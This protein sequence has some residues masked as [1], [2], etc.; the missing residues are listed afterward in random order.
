MKF[1]YFYFLDFDLGMRVTKYLN[2]FYPSLGKTWSEVRDKLPSFRKM[3]SLSVILSLNYFIYNIIYL[4]IFIIIN[5][6]SIIILLFAGFS[7]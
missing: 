4:E 7:N 3:R 1:D 5:N 6:I 2:T